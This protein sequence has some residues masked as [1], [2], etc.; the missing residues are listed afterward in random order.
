MV[1]ASTMNENALRYR[2]S[3]GLADRDEQM[4]VLVQRVS[5]DYFGDYF[6]PHL[7]GMGNSSTLY[8]CR[9][10]GV[11]VYSDIVSQTVVCR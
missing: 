2:V 8:V 10:E 7:A 4:A 3:R 1:C 9:T 6:F 5:G 11:E